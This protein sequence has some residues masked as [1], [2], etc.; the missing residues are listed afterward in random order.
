MM[1][2]FITN[3]RLFTSQILMNKQ[4]HNGWP[5]GVYFQQIFIFG[6]T[7]PKVVSEQLLTRL[8]Q[9]EPANSTMFQVNI[10]QLFHLFF[11]AVIWNACLL[12]NHIWYKIRGERKTNVCTFFSFCSISLHVCCSVYWPAQCSYR[13]AVLVNSSSCSSSRSCMCLSWR[14]LRSAFLTTWTYWSWPMPCE[15]LDFSQVAQCL[16]SALIKLPFKSLGSVR[17]LKC[18]KNED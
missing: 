15:Y 16:G 7:I 12:I 6:W 1:D 5:K 10:F 9:L 4:T 2:L 13:S 8:G 3:A 14:C 11:I 17:F 18:K